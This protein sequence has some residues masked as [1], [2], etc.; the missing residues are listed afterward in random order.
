MKLP[1]FRRI[2]KTDYAEEYRGLIETLS[3]SINNGIE[4]IYQAF[5]KAIS[6]RE[7]I[8]CTVKDI[9]VVVDSTGAPKTKLVF[10]LDTSNR[11]LGVIVLNALN[12]KTPTILPTSGVF[13]SFTQENKNIIVNSIK[14]LPA[15]Q[16]FTLTIVAF[17]S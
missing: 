9:D 14:G 5:N 3:F 10:S 16:P 2:L 6:L 7:N 15:D 4:V 17:D 13:I 8:A 12:T 11:I 1:S